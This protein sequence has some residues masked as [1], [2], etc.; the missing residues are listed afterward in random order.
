M[1]TLSE[2]PPALGCSASAPFE[3]TGTWIVLRT[4]PRHAKALAVALDKMG[5]GYYLPLQEETRYLAGKKRKVVVPVID[6]GYVFGNYRDDHERYAML[7]NAK[8]TRHI[9][10][11]NQRLCLRDLSR[12]HEWLAQ[13]IAHRSFV[14]STCNINAGPFEGKTGPVIGVRKGGKV[15]IL[16]EWLGD[17]AVEF[18]IDPDQARLEV[19]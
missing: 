9:P 6:G 18:E 3:L 19:A 11:T 15:A 17:A 10:V 14:G 16:L 5:L 2:T 4:L 8:V 7:D 13:G 1:P 12:M